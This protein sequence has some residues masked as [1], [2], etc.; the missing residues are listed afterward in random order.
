MSVAERH[1]IRH[2]QRAESGR[3][4]LAHQLGNVGLRDFRPSGTRISNI[5]Q[6]QRIRR[7]LSSM[8]PSADMVD[9]DIANPAPVLL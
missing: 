6:L 7:N 5:P 8:L 3:A 1:W 9:R 4:Q 2:H